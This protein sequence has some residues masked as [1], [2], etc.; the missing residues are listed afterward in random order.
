MRAFDRF[1]VISSA[2]WAGAFGEVPRGATFLTLMFLLLGSLYL[3]NRTGF[4]SVH[5]LFAASSVSTAI[6]MAC[7]ELHPADHG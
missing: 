2:P 1:V 5:R 6:A 3:V 4:R 7:A